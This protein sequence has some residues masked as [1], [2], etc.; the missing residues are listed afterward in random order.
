VP[1]LFHFDLDYFN[2]RFD[3]DSS[4]QTNPNARSHDIGLD[5]QLQQLRGIIDGIRKRDLYKRI[6]DIS[7]GIS[8]GF[9]PA[10]YWQPMVENIERE[11]HKLKEEFMNPLK[12]DSVIKVSSTSHPKRKSNEESAVTRA[13]KR[14]LSV[15][16]LPKRD[17]TGKIK[18]KRQRYIDSSKGID[19]SRVA[20]QKMKAKDFEGWRIQVDGKAC[21]FVKFHPKIDQVFKSYVSVDFQVPKPQ[22]G[23]HIGRIALQQAIESSAYSIFVAH[24][25]KSNIG[26]K[27]ALD[28]VGFQECENPDS[29]QL[30]MIFRK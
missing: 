24:L 23:K 26:S 27:K 6:V 28:A 9:Y 15:A 25:R 13:S 3:G 18:A 10:E 12:R 5:R 17:G 8:P 29:K 4:W 1:I 30:T 14:S 16:E 7:I 22:Q 20:V 21:G 2:N 19:S 11:L